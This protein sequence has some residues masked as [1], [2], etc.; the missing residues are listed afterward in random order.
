MCKAG[1]HIEEFGPRFGK[2]D[3]DPLSISGGPPTNID[4]DI[5]YFAFEHLDEFALCSRSFLVVQSAQYTAGGSGVVVLNE[6]FFNAIGSEIVSFVR[7]NKKPAIV[8]E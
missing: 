5:V 1:R 7:F 3:A 2:M 4:G 8:G 6:R